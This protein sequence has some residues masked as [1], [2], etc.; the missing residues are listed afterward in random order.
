MKNVYEYCAMCGGNLRKKNKN[1]A[2][3]RCAFVNY[4]N[5]R[6]TVTALV[7]NKNKIL[8]TKRNNAPFLGWWDLPGGFIDRGES[9]EDALR[10]E[11]KE[12]LGMPINIKKLFGI[13]PGTYPSTF[14]PFYILSVVFI[15]EPINN[16]L[17]VLDKEEI[18]GFK[19][20]KKEELP[21]KVAFDSNQK[22]I[23]DF[24]KTWK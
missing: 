22:I 4:C 14:E 9:S 11:M 20:F 16:D 2:C 6:P 23:K 7:F 12:E 19:W 8:L 21:K 15:V 13:Y 5:A 17:R 18:K 1:L 24:I 10:R 3:S